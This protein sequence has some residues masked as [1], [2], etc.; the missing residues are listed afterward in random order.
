VAGQKVDTFSRGMR[1]RLGVADALLKD[2]S[3]LILDEPTASLDPEGVVELL[4]LIERIALERRIAVLLSSTCWTRSRRSASVSG[5]STGPPG[6]RRFRSRPGERGLATHD[7]VEVGAQ[8]SDGGPADV[9]LVTTTLR[10]TA[11]VASVAPEAGA[12]GRVLVT[13]TPGVSGALASALAAAGLRPVHLRTRVERLDAIYSRLVHAAAEAPSAAP[14]GRPVSLP[15]AARRSIRRAPGRSGHERPEPGDHD[16]G[17]DNRGEDAAGDL[18]ERVRGCSSG[19]GAGRPRPEGRPPSGGWRIVAAK[20]LADH[21]GSTRFVALF[22]VLGLAGASAVYSVSQQIVSVAAGVRTTESLFPLLFTLSASDIAAATQQS[23][24]TPLPSFVALISLL[25]PLLG[26]AFGFD[27]VNRER[28]DRTLPGSWRNPIYR[29]D[30]INGKFAAG[31]A[32]IGIALGAV[33]V[34][35]AAWGVIQLGVVPTAEDVA[36][37]VVWYIVAIVYIGFWLA[38]ATLCSVVMRRAASSALVAISAWLVVSLFGGLLISTA[39]GLLAP[40]GVSPTTVDVIAN[41]RLQD[42]LTRISP[43]GMFQIATQAILDPRV[44]AGILT[45]DQRVAV[46]QQGAPGSILSLDQSLLVVGPQC[47]RSSP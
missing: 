6:C 19:P 8:A 39:V 22:V 30:V 15:P 23:A 9:D 34:V 47:W 26:I 18:D 14:A 21:L 37:L 10:D 32:A 11:G 35:I 7:V 41:G 1:Q 16:G 13:G 20:E 44:T 33:L 17:D 27:A 2:P 24:N 43:D 36:R 3:V 4:A 45:I 46:A 12:P 29:D 31:L 38:L 40:L 28:A 42:T 5:S 25:A